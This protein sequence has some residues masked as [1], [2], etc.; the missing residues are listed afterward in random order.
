TWGTGVAT[1]AYYPVEKPKFEDAPKW[2]Y[3]KGYRGKRSRIFTIQQ[4]VIST[5]FDLPDMKFYPDDSGHFLMAVLGTD[6]VTGTATPF[7][8]TLTQL[9]ALPPSYTLTDFSSLGSGG[10]A[11]QYTGCYVEEVTLK[12][13]ADGDLLLSA[14]GQGKPSTLVAKPSASYSTQPFFEGYQAQLT[15]AGQVNA[16]VLGMTYTIKQV[17]NVIW[18]GNNQQGPTAINVAGI[19]ISGTCDVEPNDELE[20]L[21]MLNNTQ[22]T[23]SLLFTSGSNTLTLQNTK[24]IFTKGPINRDGDYVKLPLTFEAAYNSTDAGA[25]KAILLNPRSSAY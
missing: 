4:G 18:G 11:R 12:Y 6:N 24:M 10:Q 25:F 14:K 7:T 17:V 9:D 16:R 1:T 21:Y 22:P 19:E 2:L 13:T 20:F 8:H 3:D 23:S 5:A 15:L